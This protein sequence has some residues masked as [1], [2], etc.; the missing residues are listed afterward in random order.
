[1]FMKEKA[2]GLTKVTRVMVSAEI[3]WKRRET[4]DSKTE[5]MCH[6]SRELAQLGTLHFL[7]AK[8]T[9]VASHFQ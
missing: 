4:R 5:D 6:Q 1:M 7:P 9:N 2:E 3:P 8:K